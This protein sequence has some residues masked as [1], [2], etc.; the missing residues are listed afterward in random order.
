[1]TSA[2]SRPDDTR[3]RQLLAGKLSA[4]AREHRGSLSEPQ[5]G[6]FGGGAALLVDAEAWVLLDERPEQGLGAAMAW[7]LRRNAAVV[8]LLAEGGTGCLARRAIGWTPT[9]RVWQ[10]A[11]RTLQAARPEP[12]VAAMPPPDGHMAFATLISESG[13]L[14]VIE[15][16]VLTGEV[17][18]LEVCR[19]V[20]DPAT[21]AARLE[22]GVGA[23]DREAF[24]LLHGDRP[25]AESLAEVVRFVG[26]HRRPGAT[27]HPLNLL[28]QER[29]LRCRLVADSALIGA[30]LVVPVAPPVPRTNVKDAVPCVALATIDGA[31]VTVVCSTGI[32]LD[33]VPFAVD[34]L[35]AGGS[36]RCVVV[37]PPRDAIDIQRQLTIAAPGSIEIMPIN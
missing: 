17:D 28:A 3:R 11:E 20:T 9:V 34:A 33:V 10:V 32:D 19:V 1:M 37:M 24:Q 8:N 12:L 29:A 16:G 14:P 4:L 27:R 5:V 25:T 22:V 21:G 30:Q 6:E 15:F 31:R 35:A 26:S 13:A 2:A 7:A 23:H 36:D 18:G